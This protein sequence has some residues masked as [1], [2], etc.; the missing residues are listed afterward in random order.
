[1]GIQRLPPRNKVAT[2]N[3]PT[4][5]GPEMLALSFDAGLFEPAATLFAQRD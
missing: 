3:A 5:T 1:M 4:L 2:S